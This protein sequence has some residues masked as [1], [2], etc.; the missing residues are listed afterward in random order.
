MDKND[1]KANSQVIKEAKHT[2]LRK[3][4]EQILWPRTMVPSQ[5]HG[6]SLQQWN[7]SK[8]KHQGDKRCLHCQRAASLSNSERFLQNRTWFSQLRYLKGTHLPSQS[9]WPL[10]ETPG[11]SVGHCLSWVPCYHHPFSVYPHIHI[12]PQIYAATSY[13]HCLWSQPHTFLPTCVFCPD[14]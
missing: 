4:A 2:L 3:Q 8:R 5:E 11:N 6:S 10:L 9:S 14:H 13:L 1:S 7:K 12:I